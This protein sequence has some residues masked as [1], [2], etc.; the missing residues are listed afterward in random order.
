MSAQG[1]CAQS[2]SGCGQPAFPVF[3]L[4]CLFPPSSQYM[5]TSTLKGVCIRIPVSTLPK[6]SRRSAAETVPTTQ[7]NEILFG[8]VRLRDS[9]EVWPAVTVVSLLE[10]GPLTKKWV[11]RFQVGNEARLH[12]RRGPSGVGSGLGEDPRRHSDMNSIVGWM[13]MWM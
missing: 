3:L 8:V 12:G 4:C 2:P 11:S 7:R 10:E 9:G 5:Y 13:W 6:L 1:A